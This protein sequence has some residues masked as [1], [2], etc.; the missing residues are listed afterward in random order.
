M[1][2]KVSYVGLY[3][4]WKEG[5]AVVSVTLKYLVSMRLGSVVEAYAS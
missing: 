1:S 3:P 4:D 2:R 5:G